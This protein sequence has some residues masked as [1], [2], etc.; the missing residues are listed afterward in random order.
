M[1]FILGNTLYMTNY[2]FLGA[3]VLCFAYYI[4]IS[5]SHFCVLKSVLTSRLSAITVKC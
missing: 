5:N 1:H 2:A 4:D 3:S